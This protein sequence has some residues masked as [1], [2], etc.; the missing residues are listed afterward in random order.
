VCV[1]VCVGRGAR[2]ARGT[3]VGIKLGCAGVVCSRC[4]CERRVGRGQGRLG[5]A[6]E[7]QLM[8]PASSPQIVTDEVAQLGGRGDR[9]G[10]A[11]RLPFHKERRPLLAAPSTAISPRIRAGHTT[12]RPTWHKLQRFPAD[13]G[14]SK[15]GVA[16]GMPAV[17]RSSTEAEDY[18]SACSPCG[19]CL[20]TSRARACTLVHARLLSN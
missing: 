13:A 8:A 17:G 10:A 19:P 15:A 1:C 9:K 14:P 3:R 5:G 7:L 16:G 20:F 11:A 12:R 2:G 4:R 18:G 6:E